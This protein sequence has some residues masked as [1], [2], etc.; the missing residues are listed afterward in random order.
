MMT[1]A[2]LGRLVPMQFTK[3]EQSNEKLQKR[4]PGPIRGRTESRQ[5]LAS[6]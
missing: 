4:G 6:Y 1:E 2:Y 3:Q 5:P